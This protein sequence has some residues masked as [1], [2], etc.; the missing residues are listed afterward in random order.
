M[1]TS[2][3][4]VE[5]VVSEVAGPDVLQLVK[6]LKNKKNISE[7]K[8]ASSMR[9]EIITVRN[10]LYR[11]YNANLVSFIHKKD[12]KKGWYIYY[13]T[14]NIK[15]IKHL[16]DE[17]KKKKIEK[18]TERLT[19]EK[20]SQFYLCK[21]KCLR[22]EFEQAAD[23]EFKCPECGSLLDQEDNKAKIGTLEKEMVAL[24]RDAK[25]KK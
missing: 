19:R 3:N 11:L 25:K 9:Q 8:L 7:F 6:T 2:K 20:N 16:A 23:F 22:L 14:F 10:M 4:I 17:L 1:K 13:W 12:Q 15:N 18:L 21:N 5:D 24:Q